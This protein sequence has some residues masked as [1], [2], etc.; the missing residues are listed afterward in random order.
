MRRRSRGPKTTSIG[1]GTLFGSIA[2]L[3]VGTPL[4]VL[5]YVHFVGGYADVY[6]VPFWEVVDGL[7]FGRLWVGLLTAVPIGFVGAIQG[8]LTRTLCG[9]KA[10]AMGLAYVSIVLS[11]GSALAA[12]LTDYSADTAANL[13]KLGVMWVGYLVSVGV[14]ALVRRTTPRKEEHPDEGDAPTTTADLADP[15]GSAS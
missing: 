5:E 15:Q 8:A 4:A 12:L 6:D 9:G 7:G 11:A 10:T 13:L 1:I 3:L 2:V 14:V